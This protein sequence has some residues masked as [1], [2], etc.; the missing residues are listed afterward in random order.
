M[1]LG[2]FLLHMIQLQAA[3]KSFRTDIYLQSNISSQAYQWYGHHGFSL[4]KS[5]SP[6]E[7][8][9]ELRSWYEASKNALISTPYV[10]FVTTELWNSD[11]R[12]G[13]NDPLSEEWQAQ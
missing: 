10:H 13:G 1:G 7:L 3:S 9:Q 8:P 2:T 11:V 5:N 6:E 4:T 12:Q